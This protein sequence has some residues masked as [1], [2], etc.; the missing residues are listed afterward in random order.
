MSKALVALAGAVL[1]L[2]V[3]TS[4]LAYQRVTGGG[5]A[6]A[7]EV[8]AG[9][10]VIVVDWNKELVRIVSTPGAQPA[11][12]HPTR[13]FAIMHAAIY[14]AVVSITHV[15]APY[16]FSL[17]APHGAR[18]DAA[19]A[20]AGHDTLVALYPSMKGALDQQLAAELAGISNGDAKG[21][22]VKVGH[23]AASFIL[24]A[25]A[26]DGSSVAP[27]PL[28][29]PVQPGDYRPTPPTFA[30]AAF[31]QWANVTPFV[32]EQSDQFRPGAPPTLA[33]AGY[34]R[35]LNEVKSLGQNTSTTRSADQ[36][37]AAKFWP[38]PIW[39][40]WNEIAEN[41]VLAHHTDLVR[42]SRLFALLNL[43]FADTTIAFYDAKYHY[44]LWRPITAIRE[45]DDLN[46]AVTADPNWT[47]LLTT[48]ADPSYPGAHS[49]I[50]GAGAAVLSSFFGDHDRIRV[51]SDVLPGVVRTFDTYSGAATEAGLS[52]IYGGV[53]TRIDH[54][55][56]LQL[57]RDVSGLVLREAG[58]PSFGFTGSKA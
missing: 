51:T 35:A 56:G 13:S 9:S 16:L 7:A 53:H 8:Q 17:N 22:G 24:S 19:A 29:P 46:P 37:V 1:T 48:A 49:A 31:T 11:T 20:Q 52:R 23:L 42:T 43:S 36:T 34:A 39:T 12:V 14:D 44:H 5:V 57:G 6:A 54:Q 33:S 2:A 41:S 55:A 40:T 32:L 21:Q 38:G 3:T 15:G 25:R 26:N 4:V 47:P 58:S 10:G 28:P 30:P 27:P 50:S 18:P 45:A